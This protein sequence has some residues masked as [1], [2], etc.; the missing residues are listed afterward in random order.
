[1]V[2]K[3]LKVFKVHPVPPV[4]QVSLVLREPSALKDPRV[5]R[6][7]RDLLEPMLRSTTQ[8]ARLS[9]TTVWSG[10]LL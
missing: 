5:F 10:R 9:L 2:L 1:L 7:F 3:G 4:P 8:V 6:V